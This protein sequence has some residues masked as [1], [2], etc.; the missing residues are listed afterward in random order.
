ML[1]SL[2]HSYLED[3]LKVFINNLCNYDF[4][5]Y[6][7]NNEDLFK[8]WSISCK[9][10]ESLKLKSNGSTLSTGSVDYRFGPLPILLEI[11]RILKYRQYHTI[12]FLGNTNG[13]N[14]L[15]K[16]N[17][18]SYDKLMHFDYNSPDWKILTTSIRGRQANVLKAQPHTLLY[19]TS[20][21]NF[22]NAIGPYKKHIHSI[23]TT[24][25][26]PFFR[27]KHLDILI[28]NNMINW[29]TGVNF[30]TC[31]KGHLHFL[32]IFILHKEYGINLLNMANKRLYINDDIFSYDP[33][34]IICE[35]EKTKLNSKFITHNNNN[36]R[37]QLDLIEDLKDHYANLQF[38]RED[39][40]TKVYYTTKTNTISKH[41]QEL[42]NSKFGKVEFIGG[43]RLLT[44]LG[45]YYPFWESSSRTIESEFRLS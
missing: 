35:C 32:P 6:N 30:Y 31:E 43:I 26:E 11:E 7:V 9:F 5:N 4:S 2:Y 39:D 41:D 12:F 3:D 29:K 33:N 21:E 37:Y 42:I 18:D 16:S 45:K 38:V 25:W 22:L 24:D 20:D 27:Q 10:K 15:V 17:K 34:P 13:R 23:C 14:E 36:F 19:L 1:S 28:N 8:L 40:K 44:G